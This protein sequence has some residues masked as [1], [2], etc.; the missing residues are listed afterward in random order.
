ML[1]ILQLAQ[2]ALSRNISSGKA[3]RFGLEIFP[4][5]NNRMVAYGT[6]GTLTMWNYS[7][8]ELVHTVSVKSCQHYFV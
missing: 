8:T 2:V 6:D 5:S 7:N 1:P 3:T 4:G